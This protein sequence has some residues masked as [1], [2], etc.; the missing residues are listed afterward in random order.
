MFRRNYNE[1]QDDNDDYDSSDMEAGY[2]EIERE[3]RRAA[4]IAAKE[5]AE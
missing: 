5:D 2:D 1:N 4:R 3:E